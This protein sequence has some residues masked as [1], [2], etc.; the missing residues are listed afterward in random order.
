MLILAGKTDSVGEARILM[1]SAISNGSAYNK[2]LECIAKQGGDIR[3]VK[4]YDSLINCLFIKEVQAESSGYV[5]AIDALKI[6]E[7]V[8]M[9]GGGR[10]NIDD[11]I[12][13]NVG[14]IVTRKV[15]DSV[16][17]GQVLAFVYANDD[18]KADE[19]V[20]NV[21]DAY[22]IGDTPIPTPK[23]ILDIIK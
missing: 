22:T 17:T 10:E 19:A 20:R 16:K 18:K 6:G 7:T 11:E 2:F 5:H 12:D 4:N 3:Y 8:K 13:V 1:E 21:L 9:L 23:M 14:V 15:S